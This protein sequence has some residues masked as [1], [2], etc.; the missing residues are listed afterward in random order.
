MRD[1]FGNSQSQSINNNSDMF[2]GLNIPSN[3]HDNGEMDF[4]AFNDVG[5]ESK[6]QQPPVKND[7]VKATSFGLTP[8][9]KL[10]PMYETKKQTK[11][12]AFSF[13]NKPTPTTTTSNNLSTMGMGFGGMNLTGGSSSNSQNPT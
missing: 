4:G 8:P 12:D 9:P 7:R 10:K 2:A 5:I 3:D 11:Q 1:A 6:G 13:I